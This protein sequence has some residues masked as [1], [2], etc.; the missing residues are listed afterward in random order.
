MEIED[1]KLRRA[2]CNSL[3]YT[4]V[5]ESKNLRHTLTVDIFEKF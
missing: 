3:I 4:I 2:K 5:S 1:H